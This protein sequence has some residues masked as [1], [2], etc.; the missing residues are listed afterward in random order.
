LKAAVKAVL[1][2]VIS[3]VAVAA[4]MLVGVFGFGWFQMGTANFRGRVQAT[5]QVRG[6]GAY[7]IAAYNSFYDQ[8][9][10]IQADEARID[11]LN[12]ELNGSPAPVADRV[13]QI[14]ASL[15]A[16][17]S[18][19]AEKIA[20]YNADAKKADTMANFK[21]SDLPYQI[22]PTERNTQCG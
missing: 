13:E 16:I 22:D 18:S 12:Q 6:D 9:A 17:R 14:Q 7:R 15:T 11:S 1:A 10:A 19:R 21:A 3:I 5:E 4:I 20:K 8:C 2:V